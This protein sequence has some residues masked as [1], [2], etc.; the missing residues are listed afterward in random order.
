MCQ[1]IETRFWKQSIYFKITNSKVTMSVCLLPFYWIQI[2]KTF[3]RSATRS[4]PWISKHSSL[5]CA[6][7]VPSIWVISAPTDFWQLL[8]PDILGISYQLNIIYVLFCSSIILHSF[9]ILNFDKK[10][11]IHNS[12]KTLKWSFRHFSQSYRRLKC[13]VESYIK[14]ITYPYSKGEL[15]VKESSSIHETSN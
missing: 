8:F 2:Y 14:C 6:S 1:L 12:L 11:K 10:C 13:T 15:N 7:L 5:C 9:H 4:G 3:L